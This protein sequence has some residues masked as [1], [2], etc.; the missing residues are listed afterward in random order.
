M[1]LSHSVRCHVFNPMR[2]VIIVLVMLG[3]TASAVARQP[4][5]IRLALGM[6][7][8]QSARFGFQEVELMTNKAAT[9]RGGELTNQYQTEAQVNFTAVEQDGP[10]LLVDMVYERIRFRMDSPVVKDPPV[11]DTDAPL[12]EKLDNPIA[13]AFLAIVKK[14]IRLRIAA[15]GLIESITP[16]SIE[17]PDIKHRGLAEQM[18][19]AEW[20]TPRFQP[21]FSLTAPGPD[22]AASM[23][24]VSSVAPLA[25]GVKQT[26][27][28]SSMHV[29]D[30]VGKDLVGVNIAAKAEIL[31]FDGEEQMNPRDFQFA[32]NGNATW[33]TAEG[34][35]GGRN[36]RHEWSFN[37]TPSPDLHVF[38]STSVH[39]V[40]QRLK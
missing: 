15:S 37:S 24:S 38:V 13:P 27:H 4:A 18:V 11:F 34:L 39:T 14:P 30:A 26:I 32:S 31:P 12:E 25:H 20:I 6:K 10:S 21:V 3:L 36:V 40:L 35:L 8:G 23:W 2:S 19:S 28:I 29:L 22:V 33:N 9:L 1:S 16:P 7:P 5:P 17:M